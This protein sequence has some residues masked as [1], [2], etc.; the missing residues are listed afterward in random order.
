MSAPM[1]VGML[2]FEWR[3]QVRQIT[4]PAMVLALG[5]LAFAMVSTG[6]GPPG[7]DITSPLVVAQSLGFLSLTAVFVLTFTCANAALRDVDYRM[8]EVIF[9]TP[10][11]KARYVTAR[12]G[13]AIA[14][15]MTVMTLIAVLLMVLP[16][17]LPV[18]P[19]DLGPVRPLA[20]LW[21]LVLLVLPNLLLVG[22]LLFTSAV[23]TRSAPATYVTGV[24]IY[25]AY[26]VTAMA[27][28][29]PLLA[30]S[31][32]QTADALARAALLDPFGM[33]AFF[34]QIRYWTPAERDVR[35]LSATGHMLLNRLGVL[36]IAAGVLA[37]GYRA[38]SLTVGAPVRRVRRRTPDTTPAPTTPFVPVAPVAATGAARRAALGAV[39][40]RE[41]GQVLRG[42]PF[43]ALT[44]LWIFMVTMELTS[45][46][47]A[48][49]YGSRL[50]PTTDL[51]LER[52][53]LPL[54][55]FGTITLVY[56]AADVVWRERSV[57]IDPLIDATPVSSFT[58][59]AAKVGALLLLIV[60]LTVTGIATSMV[61]QLAAGW[62]V[63]EPG[64]YLSL[65]WS[66]GMPL[67]L[68]TVGAVM[69]QVLAPNRWVGMIGGIALAIVTVRGDALGLVHPLTRY[70]AMPTVAHSELDGFGA[71]VPSFLAFGAVWT[72]A[73]VVL[74]LLAWALWRRGSDDALRRRWRALPA[75]L[76][77]RGR[78]ALLGSTG[79]FAIGGGAL[80]WRTTVQ[81][82][83][84]T[85]VDAEAWQVGYER[86]WRRLERR[87]QPDVHHVRLT[88]ALEPARRRA[89]VEGRVSLRNGS[90]GAIDSVWLSLPRGVDAPVLRLEGGAPVAA[91]PYGVYAIA[92][93]RPLAPGD[94]IAATYAFTLDRGGVRAMPAR[95]DVA[96]NGTMLMSPE[97]MPGVGYRPGRALDEPRLRAKHGLPPAVAIARADTFAAGAPLPNDR[98]LTFEA[99]VITDADQQVVAPGI[100]VRERVEAGRRHATYASSGPMTPVFALVSARYAVRRATARG[101]TVELWYDPRHGANVDRMLA[102]A[103]ATLDW[104]AERVAPPVDSVL[105]IAEVPE[106]A[107][108]GAFATRGLIL[109][110]ED[111]GF[112]VD[113]GAGMVDLITR[114]VAHEVAHQW[115]GH[116]VDPAD[117]AG[118]LVLVESLAKDAEQQVVR[119]V[120]GA[121]ALPAM[122]GYDED[123]YLIG[124]AEEGRRETPLIALDDGAW[125]YYGKGAM[126]LHALRSVL[127]DDAVDGALAE[128]VATGG[129]EGRSATAFD[130]E[131][132]L[133]VRAGGDSTA[134]REWLRGRI[135]WDFAVD[136]VAASPGSGGRWRV[137]AQLRG[138]RRDGADDGDAL[139]LPLEGERIEVLL[140]DERGAA[141]ARADATFRGGKATLTFD[142]A[143]KPAAI[144]VDPA[145]TRIDRRRSDN[146]KRI[147]TP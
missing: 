2:R 72:L 19:E 114:R 126:A 25:A 9:A 27:I 124:R 139:A 70:G 147:V 10:M 62:R 40:R 26:F 20:H 29:S 143:R 129:G 122:L 134:V 12:F 64:L 11:G 132:V 112:R 4:F 69:V 96:G 103:T 142:A 145:M 24:G 105:R 34:E 49:E 137:V 144:V 47:G 61:V 68:F 35:F 48:G 135:T 23:L 67:A 85:A 56:Y 43:L 38:T 99:T 37:F 58:L 119:R 104:M 141:I 63:L 128:L 45:E 13:G 39:V 8:R 7:T 60:A 75:V 59:L 30:G 97:L 53:A 33:S 74:A 138:D 113:G 71:V 100:L 107:G 131:R 17:V 94:S 130:L 79:L 51:L 98:W 106:W 84:I 36:A 65:F 117:V 86:T 110:P 1:L 116:R 88:V 118:G 101:T 41:F 95:N 31:T 46:L 93:P 127:G 55:L 108:F 123:R 76:G 66:V 83:W 91:D 54:L 146:V 90:G 102:A 133:L 92:L 89:T 22:A 16:L 111:R 42:W 136:S 32:P 77:A 18:D 50:L 3:H 121:D 80:W 115:W 6:Y 125:L 81:L 5:F 109:F 21:A 73:A 78:V 15:A 14:A 120:H 28:D 82:P 57:R 52:L 87:P 140:R 44:A